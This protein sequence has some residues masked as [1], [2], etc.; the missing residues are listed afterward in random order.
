MTKSLKSLLSTSYNVSLPLPHPSF[1]AQRLVKA[2]PV[3]C[4]KWTTL[5]AE[6]LT[7]TFDLRAQADQINFEPYAHA[8]VA[9][10]R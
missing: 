3:R 1:P 5:C 10:R 7:L 4:W 9:D 6:R 2:L 8:H